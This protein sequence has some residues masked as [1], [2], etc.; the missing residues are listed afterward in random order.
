MKTVNRIMWIILIVAG[1]LIGSLIG[2]AIV[3]ATYYAIM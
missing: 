3:Q 1:I 2:W